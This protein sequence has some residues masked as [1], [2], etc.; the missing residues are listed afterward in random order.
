MLLFVK[1]RFADAIRRGSKTIEIRCG[2]RYASVRPGGSVSINGH[3]RRTVA[4][5]ERYETLAELLAS[6][7]LSRTDLSADEGEQV[8]TQFYSQS[9][10]WFAIHLAASDVR[11][12]LVRTA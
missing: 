8:L 7:E 6:V 9:G 2:K 10:P 4:A 11:P 1:K 12:A 5:V 3:F